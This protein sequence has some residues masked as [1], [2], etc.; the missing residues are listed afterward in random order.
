MKG[1]IDVAAELADFDHD[2]TMTTSA[3]FGTRWNELLNRQCSPLR[4]ELPFLLN[5]YLLQC[6]PKRP[7]TARR[8]RQHQRGRYRPRL[9]MELVRVG[10]G[11]GIRER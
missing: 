6:L 2:R 8:V 4:C 10:A 9:T 5:L 1:S 3:A 11:S 7:R